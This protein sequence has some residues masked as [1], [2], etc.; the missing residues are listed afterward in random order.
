MRDFLNEHGEALR[1]LLLIIVGACA[2]CFV[3]EQHDR[4]PKP[5]CHEVSTECTYY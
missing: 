1:H 3:A 2:V 4:D 5:W